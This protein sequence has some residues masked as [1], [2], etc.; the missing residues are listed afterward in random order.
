M[1]DAIET[2]ADS[3]LK[4]GDDG[5]ATTESV[6]AGWKKVGGICALS[7]LPEDERRLYYVKAILNKRLDY[8]PY[9]VLA[10][11][12]SALADGVSV[13]DMELQAKHCTSWTR[14]SNW[15]TN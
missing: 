9:D 1:L 15:L 13:Q 4:F 3:Y 14:F 11:L 2:A 6:S 7:A 12:K 8:V 5:K 10:D